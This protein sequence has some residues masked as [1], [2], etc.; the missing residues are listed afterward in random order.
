MYFLEAR[1][2]F[3]YFHDKFN[4]GTEIS[5]LVLLQNE[6]GIST[7]SPAIS[8][9]SITT[10]SPPKDF[11]LQ[12]NA[13]QSFLLTWHVL[14]DTGNASSKWPLTMYGVQMQARD[15][16]FGLSFTDSYI[17]QF[18]PGETLMLYLTDQINNVC[19]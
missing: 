16:I 13:T 7:E 18:A 11:M 8:Q 15:N 2:I 9:Q 5:F 3:E 19:I 10:L 4:Q 17:V 1:A 6:A 12:L 14:I